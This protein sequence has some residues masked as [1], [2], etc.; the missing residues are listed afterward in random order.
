MND[1]IACLKSGRC[2]AD[3]K[4]CVPSSLFNNDNCVLIVAVFLVGSAKALSCLS[5]HHSKPG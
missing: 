1:Y 4:D 2:P 3:Q 5:S